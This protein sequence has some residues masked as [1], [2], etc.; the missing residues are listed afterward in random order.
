M[1]WAGC[2]EEGLQLD[3]SI[4]AWQHLRMLACPVTY[5]SSHPAGRLPADRPTRTWPPR[6]WAPTLGL[7]R[8]FL[9][10]APLAWGACHTSFTPTRRPAGSRYFRGFA[11]LWLCLT[12]RG[13]GW[14]FGKGSGPLKGFTM[15]LL[16]SSDVV[17]QQR[18]SWPPC[19]LGLVPAGPRR[20]SSPKGPG[21][22]HP[23]EGPRHILPFH[24]QGEGEVSPSPAPRPGGL[25]NSELPGTREGAE[26]HKWPETGSSPKKITYSWGFLTPCCW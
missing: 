7:R 3:L 6:W 8:P 26:I 4:P 13:L 25:S 24:E 16:L 19:S 20:C 12:Y 18:L 15:Q 10:L 17:C 11:G 1:T 2:W 14:T 5:A 9:P 22:W 23:G 21:D